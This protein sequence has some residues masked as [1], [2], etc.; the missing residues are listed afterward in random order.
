MNIEIENLSLTIG[1]SSILSGISALVPSGSVTAVLGAN[2]SG[3]SSFLKCLAGLIAY[4][5]EIKTRFDKF[6]K[7][8]YVPQ[9]PA[10]P[11]GMTLAEFV[12]LGR[13][14]YT[15]WYVSETS[16]DREKCKDAIS[17]LS[18]SQLADRFVETLSG[19]E[20]QRAV[21]ARAVAQEATLLLLDE[22]TSALDIV[23][24]V[25]VMSYLVTLQKKHKLTIVVA[26]HD[27]NLA[28][29]YS[30][31]TLL[32]K[33]GGMI[34]F[35]KTKSVMSTQKLSEVYKNPIEIRSH[36]DGNQTIFVKYN[37]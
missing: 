9:R 21:L 22:P 30:D 36:E 23:N 14:E 19:G 35:G 8:S 24:Q 29:N 28:L 1:N 34:G 18:L 16:S 10:V 7:I 13:S 12:L 20:L 32:L 6:G 3:K 25:E 27:L 31:R 11:V 15:K 2:G 17:S 33:D 37:L 4:D 26:L 5:G